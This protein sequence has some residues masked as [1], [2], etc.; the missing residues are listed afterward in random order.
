MG[1]RMTWIYEYSVPFTNAKGQ[2]AVRTEWQ[3]EPRADAKKVRVMS[4]T[5]K[6]KRNDEKSI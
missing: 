3:L 1:R 2:N 4:Y 5:P 6:E